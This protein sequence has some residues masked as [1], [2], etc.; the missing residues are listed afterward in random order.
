MALHTPARRPPGP[1]PA[2]VPEPV[3]LA[4]ARQRI[5][6][7]RAATGRRTAVLDDDPT[8]SQSVHGVSVVTVLEAAEYAAALAEPE[9]TCF[10]LTNTRSLD[11]ADAV[12]LNQAAGRALFE[13][14]QR[15]GAPLDLVSRS[16]STLRGHV[17]A[18]IRTLD[19]VRR[20][21]TGRGFDGV[22]LAPSYFEAGRF[23]AGDVHWAM[24][25]GEPVP[26]GE[27]EFAKDATFGYRSSDLK[28][29]VAEKS[30][31][32]VTRGAGAQHQPRGHPPRR[33]GPGR[34]DPALGQRPAA[35][36]SST[37]PS[38]RTW[39]SSCLGL[40]QV[41]REGKA[42]PAPHR[43][44]LCPRARRAR[45]QA[46]PA[47]AGHLARRP[48]GRPRARRRRLP[49]RARRRARSPRRRRAAA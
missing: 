46:D 44:V 25:G 6:D 10:I 14:E 12:A 16:D 45:P 18:E 13:L 22:L 23:T 42:V 48:P 3:R 11:E 5:R 36:R 40:Q 2:P 9:S 38:S 43:A 15:L 26:A 29:F 7:Y 39:K 30:G 24:V 19:A 34:G 35:H 28:D 32:T 49:C 8:G 4:G 21:V 17:M 27:T 41:Q 1:A 31:G 47:G 37:P 33:R 20:E